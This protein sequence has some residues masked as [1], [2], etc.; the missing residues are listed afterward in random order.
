[1]LPELIIQPPMLGF[2][3]AANPAGTRYR[4]GDARSAGDTDTGGLCKG[5][6]IAARSQICCAT[7]GHV[8]RVKGFWI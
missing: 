3:G 5:S 7:G 6:I 2:S 1:M 4:S 8:G